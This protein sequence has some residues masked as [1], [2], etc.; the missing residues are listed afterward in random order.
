MQ[1]KQAPVQN[2]RRSQEEPSQWLLW[3]PMALPGGRKSMKG[4]EPEDSFL[5]S[6]DELC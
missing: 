5:Q 3:Q 4:E 6:Q 2:Y 1:S